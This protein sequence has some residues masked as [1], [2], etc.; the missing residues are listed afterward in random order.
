MNTMDKPENRRKLGMPYHSLRVR[1]DR[2]K[3]GRSAPD[4]PEF[5]EAELIG[6]DAN[7]TPRS[8]HLYNV[9]AMN[10]KRSTD[11]H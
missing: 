11:R 7:Q 3:T 10:D 6:M 5:L 9:M 2:N 1:N 4:L 8:H